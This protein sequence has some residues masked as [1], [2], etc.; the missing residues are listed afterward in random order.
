MVNISDETGEIRKSPA[1]LQFGS[2]YVLDL[3]PGLS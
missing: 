2:G 1:N 3:V